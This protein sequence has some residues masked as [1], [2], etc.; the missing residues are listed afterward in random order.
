MSPAVPS[1]E[2]IFRKHV[3]SAVDRL[4]DGLKIAD[5]ASPSHV[6]VIAALIS[7]V[8]MRHLVERVAD[9]AAAQES[10]ARAEVYLTV[11][12]DCT[13][14]VDQP[15]ERVYAGVLALCAESDANLTGAVAA[16]DPG[17]VDALR[18][19]LLKVTATYQVRVGQKGRREVLV[20]LY[21]TATG[22]VREHLSTIG[23]P[24]DET[25]EDVRDLAIRHGE[26]TVSFT[27]YP[28]GK[29]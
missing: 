17:I 26:R 4:E 7:T 25:P 12:T 29:Q 20:Y 13:E 18:R 9:R 21:D 8:V 24:W 19:I 16:P 2:V 3:M 5:A 23:L 15:A 6:E 11:T 28:A 27:I 14:F 1:A 22:K 10:L